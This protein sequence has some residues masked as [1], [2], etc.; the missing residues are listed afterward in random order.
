MILEDGEATESELYMYVVN[1]DDDLL[2]GRGQLYVLKATNTAAYN[3]W[4]DVYYG[5]KI[6]GQFVPVNWD[7]A[8]QDANALNAAAKS[9]DA[10]Q[11]IRVEDGASDKRK[12]HNDVFYF[13]DTGNDKDEN[14]AT[15]PAGINGQSWEKGR[16][17]KMKFTD[18][19]DPTKVTFSVIID[20]NDPLA[21]GFG[22]MSNPDNLDTS[23]KSL[24][25]QEDRIGATRSS[26]TTPYDVTKNAKIIRMDLDTGSL[27]TVAYVNQ[28]TSPTAKYGDWE[29]SGIVDV[30]KP[31]GD[32]KWFVTVQAHA[33]SEQGQLLL[34]DIDG[35]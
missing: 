30:S 13:A 16:I 1:T 17:Y 34:L 6:M 10:F 18:P 14:G 24:M 12:D 5:A 22:L 19:K 23:K 9:V 20:G 4:D 11:F 32:G 29:S 21:P 28:V 31:F 7:H 2:A 3:T 33:D 25:I 35:S 15:I 26:L 27:E 8:T